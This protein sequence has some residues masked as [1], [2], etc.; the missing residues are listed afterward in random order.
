M[1]QL[2]VAIVAFLVLTTAAPAYAGEDYLACVIGYGVLSLEHAYDHKRSDDEAEKA[3]NA[4]L[5]IAYQKCRR[6]PHPPMMDG[7]LDDLVY[8]TIRRLA[9]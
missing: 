4:A 1:E 9:E 2:L 3:A 8:H 5:K 6:L 7:G